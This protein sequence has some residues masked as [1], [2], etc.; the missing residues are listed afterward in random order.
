[1][2][3]SKLQMLTQGVTLAMVAALRQ[4]AQEAQA[5]TFT[6]R[7]LLD[8]LARFGGSMVEALGYLR[9]LGEQRQALA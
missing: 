4:Y 3:L 7:E 2:A 6:D 5:G 8:L 1:M 9:A